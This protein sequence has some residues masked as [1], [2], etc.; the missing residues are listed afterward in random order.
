VVQSLVDG[1]V[2]KFAAA[3]RAARFRN[4]NFTVIQVQSREDAGG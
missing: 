1:S 3:N 2:K 4:R